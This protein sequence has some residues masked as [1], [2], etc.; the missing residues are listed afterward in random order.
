MKR[1]RGVSEYRGMD[2]KRFSISAWSDE[3]L[4]ASSFFLSKKVLT[5]GPF[6][7]ERCVFSDRKWLYKL[8]TSKRRVFKF[9]F[10]INQQRYYCTWSTV[11]PT[12]YLDLVPRALEHPVA[13]LPLIQLYTHSSCN[14][15]TARRNLLS[16]RTPLS[17][18]HV[19]VPVL[20]ACCRAPAYGAG[21]PRMLFLVATLSSF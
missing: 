16:T 1:R 17:L 9:L 8:Y 10:S 21:L 4:A 20:C 2:T 11:G 19:F 5:E 3:R 15:Q 6:F 12:Y 7:L 13:V 14:L 18:Q